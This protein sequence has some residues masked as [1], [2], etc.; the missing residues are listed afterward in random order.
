[1]PELV[2]LVGLKRTMIYERLK[3]G[4]KYADGSFPRPIKLGPRAIGFLE[5]EVQRWIT[6]RADQRIEFK[7]GTSE[8]VA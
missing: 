7:F 1:M 3:I 2:A 6:Q 8:E 4:G 5:S